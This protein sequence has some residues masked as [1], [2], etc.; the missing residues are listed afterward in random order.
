MIVDNDQVRGKSTVKFA[1]LAQRLPAERYRGTE[2]T[3]TRDFAADRL[4]NLLHP[5]RYP[6]P[7]EL[8]DYAAAALLSQPSSELV[9]SEKARQPPGN[10][11]VIGRVDQKS[12]YAV[13]DR[14]GNSSGAPSYRRL[15]TGSSFKKNQPETLDGFQFLPARHHEDIT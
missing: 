8:F 5:A 15:A 11:F 2:Q 14:V 1:S 13:D 9:V 12:G 3:V 7:S 10:I 4:Q 6:P